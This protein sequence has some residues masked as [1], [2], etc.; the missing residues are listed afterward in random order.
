[1]TYDS[2]SVVHDTYIVP[3]QQVGQTVTLSPTKFI[4]SSCAHFPRVKWEGTSETKHEFLGSHI[5]SPFVYLVRSWWKLVIRVYCTM[6]EWTLCWNTA[7]HVSRLLGLYCTKIDSA[8]SYHLQDPMWPLKSK[9]FFHLKC[10]CQLFY[11]SLTAH[12]HWSREGIIRRHAQEVS[13]E[14]F[15]TLMCRK[16]YHVVVYAWCITAWVCLVLHHLAPQGAARVKF[17]RCCLLGITFTYL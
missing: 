10:D 3:Q 11:T 5:L 7:V 2:Q 8:I 6:E 15:P 12:P 14:N 1:M 4:H 17:L 16:Y 9:N 13:F